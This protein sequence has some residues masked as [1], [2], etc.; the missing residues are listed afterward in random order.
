MTRK[1][2]LIRTESH[3]YIFF[4]T[5]LTAAEAEE[6]SYFPHQLKSVLAFLVYNMS[7]KCLKTTFLKEKWEGMNPGVYK[8]NRTNTL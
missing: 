1:L 6:F 2:W 7:L 3:S 4:D 8:K 5:Y